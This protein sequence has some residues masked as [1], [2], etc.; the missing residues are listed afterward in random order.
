M[1]HDQINTFMFQ[2]IIITREGRGPAIVKSGEVPVL[3]QISDKWKVQRRIS[4]QVKLPVAEREWPKNSRQYIECS[5]CRW[6][7]M[8][9]VKRFPDQRIQE[10][11]ETSIIGIFP[12]KCCGKRFNNDKNKIRFFLSKIKSNFLLSLP[13]LPLLPHF[14]VNLPRYRKVGAYT[15]FVVRVVRSFCNCLLHIALYSY[16]I[17]S[18]YHFFQK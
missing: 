9:P 4:I 7:K 15:H 13:F 10:G 2:E 17:S 1:C 12:A 5:F 6:K 14:P 8:V 18:S 3:L 11:H 16:R